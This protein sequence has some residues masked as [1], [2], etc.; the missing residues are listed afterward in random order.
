MLPTAIDRIALAAPGIEVWQVRLDRDAGQVMQC[1]DLLSRDERLRAA[2]FHF[3]YDRRRY[4]VARAVL[5][6]LLGDRLDIAPAAIKFSYTKRGK[7]FVAEP[8]ARIHFNVSHSAERALYAISPSFRVGADIEYLN[9]D[10][11]HESLADRFFTRA[12]SAALQRLPASHRKRAFLACW[13]RKEAVVKALGDGLSLAF[14]QFEV[15]TALDAAPRVLEFAVK[16]HNVSD[17]ALY[18]VNT[19]SNYVATVACICR[20]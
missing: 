12:E 20:K 2:R 9:R 4:T 15:T 11:D 17:W 1:E 8:A 19:N 7:P 16:A 5:R 3:E 6:M 14:D 13:T 18:S 10:I